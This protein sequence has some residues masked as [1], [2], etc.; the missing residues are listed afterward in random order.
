MK[1]TQSTIAPSVEKI[2]NIVKLIEDDI[3]TSIYKRKRRTDCNIML[4]EVYFQLV[5]VQCVYCLQ[6]CRYGTCYD[7]DYYFFCWSALATAP[8]ST[9]ARAGAKETINFIETCL[10][11]FFFFSNH[12]TTTSK[13]HRTLKFGMQSY[14]NPTKRNMKNM[15]NNRNI[16]ETKLEDDL[17]CISIWK[18]TSTFMPCC[19]FLSSPTIKL[20]LLS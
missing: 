18:R 11:F 15:V 12:K 4:N 9:S 2:I 6:C 16:L 7:H 8:A 10:T 19:L 17:N 13:Q 14:F 3:I 20:P 1:N 5:Q